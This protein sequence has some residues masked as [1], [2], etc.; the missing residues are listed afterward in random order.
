MTTTFQQVTD[1]GRATAAF[2][3]GIYSQRIC[4]ES[5]SESLAQLRRDIPGRVLEMLLGLV[6]TLD[7]VHFS[8]ERQTPDR[9]DA[10][11]AA[12]RWRASFQRELE[13]REAE[14]RELADLAIPPNSELWPL[15]EFG[16]QLGNIHRWLLAKPV[17]VSFVSKAFD[18]VIGIDPIPVDSS[19]DDTFLSILN[20]LRQLLQHH[21]EVGRIFR[22]AIVLLGPLLPGTAVGLVDEFLSQVN[23]LVGSVGFERIVGD[24]PQD[25]RDAWL[26]DQVKFVAKCEELANAL[27]EKRTSDPSATSWKLLSADGVRDAIVRYAVRHDLP[28][29]NFPR[30]RPTNK[31]RR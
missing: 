31:K 7:H 14:L 10:E 2:N 1:S 16:R 28:A 19:S 25:A 9:G 13:V 21:R 18:Q 22:E 17:S 27:R 12:S 4:L 11:P 5:L 26:Y 3:L 24:D 30:G 23:A 15:F 6:R 20:Q 29:I 8:S